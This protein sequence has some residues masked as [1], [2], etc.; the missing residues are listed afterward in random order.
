MPD[1]LEGGDP[2][3]ESELYV[4]NE[5]IYQE[6]LHQPWEQVQQAW[7][8]GFTRLVENAECIAEIDLSNEKKYAWLNGYALIAVLHG[9]LEHHVE[10][11]TELK[12]SLQR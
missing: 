9:T 10:H 8:A 4:Y 12:H 11:L 5:R 1:W 7:R 2:E 3:S 6:Y